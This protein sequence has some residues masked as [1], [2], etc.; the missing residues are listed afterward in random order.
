VGALASYRPARRASS[1]D[2]MESLRID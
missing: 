2:P 1:V